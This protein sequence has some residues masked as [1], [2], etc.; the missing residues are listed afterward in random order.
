[1]DIGN[2]RNNEIWVGVIMLSHIS[3]ETWGSDSRDE[4]DSFGL[5]CNWTETFTI[6][7]CV[8][9]FVYAMNLYPCCCRKLKM[10]IGVGF[11]FGVIFS[12]CEIRSLFRLSRIGSNVGRRI[13]EAIF[14]YYA[15]IG[16]VVYDS[17]QWELLRNCEEKHVRH[18]LSMGW[19][20]WRSRAGSCAVGLRLEVHGDCF[21]MVQGVGSSVDISI[22]I[23]NL[24]PDGLRIIYGLWM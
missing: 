21:A 12:T 3:H 18:G 13:W 4:R 5:E 24:L 15:A 14:H 1:M 20:G 16:I 22:A 2:S 6:Q 11:T 9:R 19:R 7:V 17:V 23:R 10:M 8:Y